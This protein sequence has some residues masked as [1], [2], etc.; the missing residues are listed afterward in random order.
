MKK[1]IYLD[2]AFVLLL[3]WVIVATLPNHTISLFDPTKYLEAAQGFLSGKPLFETGDVFSARFGTWLPYALWIKFF[4]YGFHLT[5][6]TVIQFL[7]LLSVMYFFLR[8]YNQ[9]VGFISTLIIGC[10]LTMGNEAGKI[11]GDIAVTVLLTLS[12]MLYWQVQKQNSPPFPSLLLGIG[13]GSIWFLA[14][15][16]KETAVYYIPL[17]TFFCI[18]DL[19]NKKRFLFW[20]GFIGT[21]ALLG[22]LLC[23]IWAYYTGDFWYRI[24]LAEGAVAL[25]EEHYDTKTWAGLLSRLSYRPLIFF[26]ENFEFGVLFLFAVIFFVQHNTT[27]NQ[28]FWKICLIGTTATWWLGTQKIS[29]GEYSPIGFLPRLWLPVLPPAAI[30]MAHAL[31]KLYEERN[32]GKDVRWTAFGASTLLLMAGIFGFAISGKLYILKGV[33][34]ISAIA[35]YII[36]AGFN[37]RQNIFV[38]VQLQKI[39]LYVATIHII[40]GSFDRVYWW[41]TKKAEGA[42]DGFTTER[43]SAHVLAEQKP[44]KVLSTSA[45]SEGNWIY[46]EGD[47]T[48]KLKCMDY[49][50]METAEVDTMHQVFLFTDQQQLKWKKSGGIEGG[51]TSLAFSQKLNPL[52]TEPERYGFRPIKQTTTNTIYYKE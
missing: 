32:W 52:E 12:V 17:F 15:L 40:Y 23:C 34:I 13:I 45:F 16:T 25:A 51:V 37:N 14:F 9:L 44:E 31:V 5:W 24:H 19:R 47:P 30:G 39:I 18:K 20:G 3:G 21:V 48:K 26:A 50:K 22:I 46:F 41:A 7:I 35:I 42:D 27:P 49:E 4:G 6:I 2:T 33:I 10:S 29:G 8:P 28:R 11:G 1:K 38:P 36:I 43:L